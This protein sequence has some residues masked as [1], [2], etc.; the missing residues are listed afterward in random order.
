MPCSASWRLK[1]FKKFTADWADRMKTLS[2]I[3][4]MPSV[5][6][7]L[8]RR[9]NSRKSKKEKSILYGFPSLD[10]AFSS[11]DLILINFNFQP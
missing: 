9:P 11:F 1:K 8:E 10:L 4:E 7:L 6:G 2:R 3:R 5:R